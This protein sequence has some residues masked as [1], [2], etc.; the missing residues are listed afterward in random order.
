MRQVLFAFL[1]PWTAARL[2]QVSHACASLLRGYTFPGVLQMPSRPDEPPLLEGTLPS[3]V[4][5]VRV[6]KPFDEVQ[7]GC[8]PHEAQVEYEACICREH[9]HEYVH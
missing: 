2:M 7:A 6:S 1:D 5:W 9:M 3:G 8:I 4:R